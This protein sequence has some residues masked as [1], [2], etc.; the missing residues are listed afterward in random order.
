[1]LTEEQRGFLKE[2]QQELN[3]QDHVCQAD[4]RFWV[5]MERFNEP[6]WDEQADSYELVDADGDYRVIGTLSEPIEADGY[7]CVPTREVHRIAQNTMFLTLREAQEHISKNSYHYKHP[8][9]YAMTAWRSPQVE[10]L[11]KILQEADWDGA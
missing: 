10:Q 5:V 2:L 3:T 8:Y 1:M 4:P 9:T 6:C 11:I 7:S